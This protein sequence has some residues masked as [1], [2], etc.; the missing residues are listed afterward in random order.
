MTGCRRTGP[1]RSAAVR[2]LLPAPSLPPDG[3]A[4]RPGAR[5]AD[6]I[7]SP[8]YPIVDTLASRRRWSASRP[9]QPPT[10]Y[11][12][13]RWHL[14]GRWVAWSPRRHRSVGPRRATPP[15]HRPGP[16]GDGAA[17]R[18]GTRSSARGGD[19]RPGRGR[20]RR[21]LR[22]LAGRRG[23]GAAARAAVADATCSREPGRAG[24]SRG[25]HRTQHRGPRAADRPARHPGR[26]AGRVAGRGARRRADAGPDVGRRCSARCS[27]SPATASRAA[28]SCARGCCRSPTG[29]LRI[30]VLT[31]PLLSV[32]ATYA[33]GRR[34]RR[35]R[36]RGQHG[37]RHQHAAVDQDAD[38]GAGLPG[39]LRT[40]PQRR[41]GRAR[42]AAPG[43]PPRPPAAPRCCTPSTP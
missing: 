41:A 15:G 33:A 22:G 35:W 24:P 34:R 30:A 11:W 31:D 29:R 1:G 6:R 43:G 10:T 12:R 21:P 5:R 26:G 38:R 28:P 25:G 14:D 2:M 4:R 37:G 23:P 9:A 3:R 36:R 42:A 40:G 7:S 32:P 19:R 39:P 13:R 16:G 8:A 20:G 27:P 17:M 18:S